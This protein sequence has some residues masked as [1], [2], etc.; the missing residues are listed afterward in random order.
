MRKTGLISTVGLLGGFLLLAVTA[1][2]F[3]FLVGGI[4]SHFQQAKSKA[5]VNPI[6]GHSKISQDAP[7]R[8]KTKIRVRSSRKIFVY[9]A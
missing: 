6:V 2:M 1:I 3:A 4:V 5:S 7:T 9:V 8:S